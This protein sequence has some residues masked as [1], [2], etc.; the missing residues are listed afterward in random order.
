MN[1]TAPGTLTPH[2]PNVPT[3]TFE[4]VALTHV[5]WPTRAGLRVRSVNHPQLETLSLDLPSTLWDDGLAVWLAKNGCG[6]GLYACELYSKLQTEG[7]QRRWMQQMIAKGPVAGQITVGPEDIA[8]GAALREK[9]ATEGKRGRPSQKGGGEGFHALQEQRIARKAVTIQQQLEAAELAKVTL[10]REEAEHALEEARRRREQARGPSAPERNPGLLESVVALVP[11]IKPMIDGWMQAQRERDA[12]LMRALAPAEVPPVQVTPA[13]AGLTLDAV[14]DYL[15]RIRELV[16]MFAGN[17]PVGDDEGEDTG[18]LGQVL[19]L[20]KAF[21]IGGAQ[22]ATPQVPAG[23][24]AALQSHS[25]GGPVAPT[26]KEPPAAGGEVQTNLATARVLQWFSAVQ[27][28][29]SVPSDPEWAAEKLALDERSPFGSLPQKFQLLVLDNDAEQVINGLSA[30]LPAGAFGRLLDYLRGNREAKQWL[31]T[32]IEAV[33]D[34]FADDT[35][36][37][38]DPQMET[39]DAPADAFMEEAAAAAERSK[40]GA[41]AEPDAGNDAGPFDD[42]P[43]RNARAFDAA[44]DAAMHRKTRGVANES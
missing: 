20:T 7:G 34:G 43:R 26:S 24:P 14:L 44:A 5:Q 41:P 3:P 35:Q 4:E 36:E 8:K 31:V 42:R 19:A 18:M 29:A 27:K 23:R 30:W 40:Q 25:P 22:A 39:P 32:F 38:G 21:G 10:A 16:K 11:L 33:Q 2:L 17:E 28:E 1:D 13:P 9:E 37:E 15:P 6:E 12:M